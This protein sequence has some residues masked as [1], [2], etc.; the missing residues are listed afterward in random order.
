M[1]EYDDITVFILERDI[2]ARQA[3]ISY[4]G[5]DRRTRVIG[6]ASTLHEMLSPAAAN[7]PQ[8]PPDV[9][10]LDTGLTSTVEKLEEYIRLILSKMPKTSII[11]L[12]HHPDPAMAASA[13]HLRAR[14]YLARTEVGV[15]IAPAICFTYEHYFVVT[16]DVASMLPSEFNDSI[17]V[18]VLPERRR[19]PNLTQR[20]EQALFLCV[21]EG[22]PAE[23]AAE[24]MGVST[25][26]VRS[27]IKQ[28]YRILE[29]SDDESYPIAM[30]PAERAFVRYSALDDRDY[31]PRS[32]S[33]MK[34]V[35]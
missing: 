17:R 33:P 29:A 31:F 27:Y 30:S 9:V 2:Y 26:T 16:R 34:S 5:W 10:T 21:I 7:Y 11:C 24:E 4:L 3:I 19:Y 18:D 35:A 8:A 32:P 15:A 6:Q 28:V 14:G 20:L 12:A 25:S 13:A 22:L 1:F 23:V